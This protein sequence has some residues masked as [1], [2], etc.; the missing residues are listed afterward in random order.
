MTLTL[1]DV[2]LLGSGLSR[3]ECVL[4]TAKGD[5]Y[6]ADWRGGVAHLKPDGTQT[7]YSATTADLPEGLRPNGIAL[8]PDGSFLLANLGSEAGGVWRLTRDGQVAPYWTQ[9]DGDPIAPSNYLVRDH[10][11]R[12]WLT[13]STTM[14]PRSLDYRRDSRSGFIAVMDDKGARIVADGLGFTNECQISPDRRWLY[15][16]ETYGRRLSRFALRDDASLGPKEVIHEF[17]EGQFP[18]GLAFDAEGRIW[19][20][21][22]IS[23]QLMRIDPESGSCEIMLSETDPAH[24][25][26]VEQAYQANAL[27]RPHMD[28][29][30]ST[31]LRN[32]S[33]IAFGG[34]DLRTGYLGCLLGGSI[35]VTRLDV[36]GVPP[37]HW[38]Y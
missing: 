37:V 27:G 9:I 4:A 15:V 11:G 10:L 33:S 6:T 22:V 36:A 1:E 18:D 23:N 12:L 17:G 29:N 21:G 19:I 20:A 14:V 7:L 3:P 25:A 26:W 30:P 5:L 28:A 32:L 38:L 2:S 13:V 16:N 8:E 31:K 35:A 34:A 24:V